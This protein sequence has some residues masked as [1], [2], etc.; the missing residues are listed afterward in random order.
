MKF[1]FKILE[2]NVTEDSIYVDLNDGRTII[3]PLIWYPRLF[4]A[5]QEERENWR[6]IGDGDGVHWA[7]LD[8]DISIKHFVLGRRSGES[9]R[10]LQQWLGNRVETHQNAPT[11]LPQ[12]PLYKAQESEET[13]PKPV[14]Q[15]QKAEDQI[16]P[17]NQTLKRPQ[18]NQFKRRLL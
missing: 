7:F 14:P 6:L 15:E 2:L 13:Q 9:Q 4:N 18:P 8:E 16:I 5:S 1:D 3:V 17:P 11:K 12:E 10:S